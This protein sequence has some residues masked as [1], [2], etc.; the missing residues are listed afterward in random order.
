[1]QRRAK[2]RAAAA[3]RLMDSRI[4]CAATGHIAHSSN[5][6]PAV[7]AAVTVA[8]LPI[9]RTHTCATLSAMTG[10]TLPGMMELPGCTSGSVISPR[11]ARGPDA[12][13][14]TSLATFSSATAQPLSVPLACT[15]A[16]MLDCAL[17][18]L[19]VSVSG[20]PCRARERP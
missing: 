20:S 13:H 6:P 16:S 3:S 8:W 19:A 12:A 2:L 9:T 1:M 4:A 5:A 7:A 14:R 11:P 10:F 18:W 17:K 15:T